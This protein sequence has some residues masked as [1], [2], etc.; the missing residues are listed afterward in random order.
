MASQRRVKVFGVLTF[1]V[2]VTILFWTSSLRREHADDFYIRTVQALDQQPEL[3]EPL[4]PKSEDAKEATRQMAERLNEAARVA[5]SN[6]NA[7]APKPDSP[8]NLVGVGNAA[9]ATW[10]RRRPGSQDQSREET[11]E[12][13]EVEAELNS[14]LKRS[15]SEYSPTSIYLS[16]AR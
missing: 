7:K 12:D 15:P 3:L 8:R 9:D 4:V 6:A 5:K 2:V 10:E 13:H 11:E 16:C 1:L 14:I